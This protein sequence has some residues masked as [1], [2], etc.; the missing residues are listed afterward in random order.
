MKVYFDADMRSV[1]SRLA[2]EYQQRRGVDN[3]HRLL[4]DEPPLPLPKHEYV[5]EVGCG[6]G[7]CEVCHS[8][9]INDGNHIVPLAQGE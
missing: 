4:H 6:I 2:N 8:D 3:L 7:F 1:Y 9:D 5:K